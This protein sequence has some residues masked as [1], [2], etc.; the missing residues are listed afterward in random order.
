[1][2]EFQTIIM[3][4]FRIISLQTCYNGPSSTFTN[5]W[6]WIPFKYRARMVAVNIR[7]IQDDNHTQSGAPKRLT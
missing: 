7:I 2:T 3:H 4:H 5:S 6:F 1:M